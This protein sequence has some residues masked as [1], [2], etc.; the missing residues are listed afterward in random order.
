MGKIEL[1]NI[2]FEFV[3]RGSGEPILFVHGSASD[4]R[5]W[6]KQLEEFGKDY[7][8]IAYSRRYHYPNTAIP[9]D[10]DYSMIEHVDDL[11][12]IIR[13]LEIAPVHLVGHS[14]GAFVSMML[15]SRNPGI[16]SSLVLAEPPAITLF[17]SN[18]PKPAELVKLALKRPRTAAAI[19]KLGATGFD[20]AIK[21]I[22]RGERDTAIRKFGMAV[23]GRK[24]FENLS[25]PRKEIVRANHIDAEFTG[26]GYPPLDDNKLRAIAIPT[27]LINGQNS[28]R[29]FHRLMD[30]LEELIPNT[31]RVEIPNASHLMHEDS[32]EKYNKVLRDFLKKC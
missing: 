10:N 7:R 4:Y 5:T 13:S 11:E 31:E 6:E 15:A 2:F 24:T 19:I 22:E 9:D 14:Y 23:L 27:L 32:T 20:P 28:P 21:A 25:G 26:S 18:K 16:A 1:K 30:R 17:V 8:A 12:A 3:E 29:I